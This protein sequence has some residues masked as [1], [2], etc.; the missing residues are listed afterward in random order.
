M[1][2]GEIEPPPVAKLIGFRLT[3]VEPGQALIEFQPGPRH[4]NPQG[5][6]HGGI[7]CDVADAAMGIAFGT[8]LA[9]DVTFTTVELKINFL[10]PAQTNPLK[11][12]GRVVKGGRRVGFTD[13]EIRDHQDRLIATATSTCLILPDKP[14]G[15]Y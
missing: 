3:S 10:R 14:A 12:L 9:E 1:A 6:V 15:L 11:V 5:T 8:T 13:C 2:R 4:Y 7:L